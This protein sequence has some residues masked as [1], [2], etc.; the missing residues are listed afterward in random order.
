VLDDGGSTVPRLHHGVGPA[1]WA[2]LDAAVPR[3]HD[4]RIGLE[5]VTT[6]PDGRRAVDNAAL[7]VEAV[8][9]YR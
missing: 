3:G 4:I 8:L 2:V 6:L 1:T 7:V 9:R 5:D